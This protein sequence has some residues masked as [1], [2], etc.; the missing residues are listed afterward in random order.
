MVVGVH[1]VLGQNANVRMQLNI[2]QGFATIPQLNME[3]N[4]AVDNKC[5]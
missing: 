4:I 1:G 3:E 5:L 2:G